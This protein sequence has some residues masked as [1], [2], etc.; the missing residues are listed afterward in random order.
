MFKLSMII[1]RRHL[2]ANLA[3]GNSR[4][5]HKNPIMESLILSSLAL[6]IDFIFVMWIQ[7]NQDWVFLVIIYAIT[8]AVMLST[9]RMRDWVRAFFKGKAIL[10]YDIVY[11]A[12][13]CYLF[14]IVPTIIDKLREDANDIKIGDRDFMYIYPVL[15][16][17]TEIFL[18]WILSQVH[19]AELYVYQA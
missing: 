17:C 13:L 2:L 12:I 10:L 19:G 1:Y 11:V 6:S 14:Y 7:N 3:M 15:D 9:F 5:A 18:D 8:V 4:Q 16:I